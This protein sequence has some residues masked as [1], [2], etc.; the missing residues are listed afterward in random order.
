MIA[1]NRNLACYAS[2][3]GRM[4]D[5]KERLRDATSLIRMFEYWHST[6][7]ISDLCGIGLLAWSSHQK[8]V[9]YTI[10]LQIHSRWRSATCPATVVKL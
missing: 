5:A 7:K 4:E 6:M 2:V 8:M 9:R 10:V 1:F 3:T